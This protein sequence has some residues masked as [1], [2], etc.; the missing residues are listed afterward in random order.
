MVDLITS[1]SSKIKSPS[2]PPSDSMNF[3]TKLVES[4]PRSLSFQD[5]AI[6][7]DGSRSTA[8]STA[9]TSDPSINLT[10]LVFQSLEG[11]E[12]SS[13]PSALREFAIMLYMYDI[14]IFN[15]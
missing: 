2:L 7:G 5:I 10:F 9:A 8:I 15:T 12:S 6:L 14:F 13:P 1:P 3:L 4:T 11:R